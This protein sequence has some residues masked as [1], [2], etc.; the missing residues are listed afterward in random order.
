[1]ETSLYEQMGG[2]YTMQGNYALPDLCLP[3]EDSRST[4]VWGQR[5]L[6][7]LKQHHRVLYCNLLTSRKLH[8]HLADREDRAQELFHQLVEQYAQREGLTEQL[9]AEKLM[10]WIRRMNN[11]HARAREVVHFEVIF[12]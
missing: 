9:R 10:D 12:T 4:S 8:T 6:C 1:M 3:K 11:I 7:F 2:S 5:R